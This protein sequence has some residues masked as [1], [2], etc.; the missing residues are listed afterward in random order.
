MLSRRAAIWAATSVV[1]GLAPTV[2][3]AAELKFVVYRSRKEFR[4]R[5]KA[6][7]G[8]VIATSGEGY[9]SRAGCLSAIERIRTGA[10][11]ATIEDQTTAN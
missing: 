4:W 11:T 8:Q 7:N 1:A 9:A 10:A 3:V 6:A 5:L 2:A